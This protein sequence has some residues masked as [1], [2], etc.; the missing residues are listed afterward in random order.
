MNSKKQT[1]ILNAEFAQALAQAGFS[2]DYLTHAT[3]S[4]GSGE[5]VELTLDYALTKEQLAVM[6]HHFTETSK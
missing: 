4:V 2:T 6:G 5:M 3:I 1:P